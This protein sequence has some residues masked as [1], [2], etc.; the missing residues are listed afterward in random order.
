MARLDYNDPLA[1]EQRA[2]RAEGRPLAPWAQ[3]RASGEQSTGPAD[4]FSGSGLVKKAGGVAGVFGLDSPQLAN[5]AGMYN[6]N[7]GAFNSAGADETRTRQ[8][9]L[10]SMLEQQARGE[11]PSIAQMQ[12]QRGTDAALAQA[13]ALGRSQTGQ[14]AGLAQRNIAQQQ[15]QIAQQ[16]ASDSALV[17]MQEQLGARS[18]LG[19]LLG[20]IRGQDI[21]TASTRAQLGQQGEQNRIGVL[22]RQQ[23]R[24]MGSEEKTQQTRKDMFGGFIETAGKAMGSMSDERMKEGVHDAGSAIDRLLA[25]LDAKSYRYKEPDMDGEGRRVGVMAQDLEKSDLGSDLVRSTSRGKMVDYDRALPLLLA[26]SARL[27]DRLDA[28]EGGG[29][30]KKG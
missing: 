10:A 20:G 17:R 23:A 11:G 8:G 30:R 4:K 25:G 1:V 21:D 2:A 14:G 19:G 9:A 24:E 29:R 13:M 7:A 16:A 3:Q 15:A 22:E 5:I 28:L 12:L 18:A 6:P 27:N 26:A